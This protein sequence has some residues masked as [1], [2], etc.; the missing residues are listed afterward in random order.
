MAQFRDT[1]SMADTTIK[2]QIVELYYYLS[3]NVKSL[4]LKEQSEWGEVVQMY[5]IIARNNFVGVADEL[6]NRV[7]DRSLKAQGGK[8]VDMETIRYGLY[9]I[10][11]R[12]EEERI[13][14]RYSKR[15]YQG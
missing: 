5:D 12:F 11:K 10:P 6:K 13:F 14:P 3:W 1:I 4:S 9:E 2:N 8:L 7:S 15:G